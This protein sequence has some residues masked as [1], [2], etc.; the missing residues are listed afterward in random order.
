M[1]AGSVTASL[2][3]NIQG[4]EFPYTPPPLKDQGEK[5]QHTAF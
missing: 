4:A 1:S 2:E 3:I 5:L